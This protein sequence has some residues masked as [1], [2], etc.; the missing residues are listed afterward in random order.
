MGS[1][2]NLCNMS[3]MEKFYLLTLGL[4]A[5]NPHSQQWAN[6]KEKFN[7]IYASPLIENEHCKT[8]LQKLELINTHNNDITKSFKLGINQFSDISD[9]EFKNKFLMQKS[10]SNND[11]VLPYPEEDSQFECPKTFVSE[12]L[13]AEFNTSFDWRSSDLSLN[14]LGKNIVSRVKNHGACGSCYSFSATGAIE[15]SLCKQ[16]AEN[17]DTWHGVSEQQVLNCGSWSPSSD[18]KAKTWYEFGG[19]NGG[20]QSNV[21]QYIYQTGGIASDEIMPYQSGVENFGNAMNIGKCPYV[22]ESQYDF[23]KHTSSGYINKDICGTTSKNSNTNVQDIKEALYRYGPLAM[24]MYVGGTF[25]STNSGVYIPQEGDCPNYLTVGINHA[26]LFVGYGEEKTDNGTIPYWIVKN[27]WDTTF[28]EDGF[29]KVIMGQNACGCEGNI[30]YVEMMPFE[31]DP[32]PES[33]TKWEVEET[34]TSWEN[35]ETTKIVTKEATSSSNLLE[36]SAGLLMV[37]FMI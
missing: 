36:L 33:T 26:M 14:P 10:V 35:E 13:P 4:V 34:T 28:A 29:V 21:F 17:C 16:G 15:G 18:S 5:A 3:I 2:I 12:G 32:I 8:F 31:A 11:T 37:L 9:E 23:V 25:S 6:F 1:F 27:S 7:K 22:P 30:A 24:G 19:C 20:W